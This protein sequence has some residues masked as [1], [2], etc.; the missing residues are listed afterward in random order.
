MA[1]VINTNFFSR[2]LFWSWI[3]G[4]VFSV[5]TE[6]QE[7]I[8]VYSDYLT[9]NLFLLHPSL[10]GATER[11]QIRLT[12]RQQ[13]FDVTDAP[14]LQTLTINGRIRE[15]EGIGAIIFNDQNGN[16]SRTGAY[17]AF[18]YH[19][20]LPSEERELHQL[21]FG[22]S[23]GVIQ[24]S[25]DQIGFDQQDPLLGNE[26]TSVAY[27]NM[28]L[29]ISYF[30]GEFYTHFS[31]RN[32]L[33]VNRELFNSDNISVNQRKYHLTS[34]YIFSPAYDWYLEPSAMFQLSEATL[35]K[36][37]DLNIKTYRNFEFGQLWAGL[38]YRQGLDKT[39]ES[40]QNLTYLT[41]FAGI[42]YK[43][44]IFGYTYSR[45]FN[46]IVYSESGYHQITLGYNFGSTPKSLHCWCP[47]IN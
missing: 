7:I 27:V 21:S 39:T 13:W 33:P 46:E 22:L 9:D 37:V 32:L 19:L 41:P 45:Q 35:E 17:A 47:A 26:N 36:T 43:N 3:F 24:H 15:K 11:S 25:L 44:F 23:A 20:R 12:A 14:G 38:S 40:G 4:L 16:F 30:R 31:A 34:G 8:P 5:K 2:T 6:A 29:G 28:D 18:A 1:I 42:E 10:A